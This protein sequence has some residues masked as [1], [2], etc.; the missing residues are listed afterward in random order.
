MSSTLSASDLVAISCG[1]KNEGDQECHWC[2][3]K[4]RRVWKHDEPA[5]IPFTRS[6]SYARRP[7]SPYLCFGCW[8]FRWKRV[9]VPFLGGGYKDG[10]AAENHSLWITEQGI[11]SIRLNEEA[12][13]KALYTQLLQPP[14]RC[15]LMLLE[16]PKQVNRL[17]LAVANDYVNGVQR[18]T[19]F[20]FTINNI[21]HSYTPYDLEEALRTEPQGKP[22]GVQA[23]IRLLGPYTLPARENGRPEK[24]PQGR[25]KP[26]ED[27]RQLKKIVQVQSGGA[28]GKVPILS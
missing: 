16:G 12:D 25:P 27:G 4:T 21:L 11:W 18:D 24:M 2:S 14:L 9:T 19:V 8:R 6:T 7:S 22:P 10:Q 28:M 26:L 17:H 3:S 20:E 1:G 13:R 5:T 23:L 15:S